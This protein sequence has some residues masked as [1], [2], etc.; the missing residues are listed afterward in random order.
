MQWRSGEFV[1]AYGVA[2]GATTGPMPKPW[3]T[4]EQQRG[5]IGW[6]ARIP[7]PVAGD[8]EPYLLAGRQ[9]QWDEAEGKREAYEKR[10]AEMRQERETAEAEAAAE[11][12]KAYQ[13]TEAKKAKDA[14]DLARGAYLAS[15]GTTEGWQRD[16]ERV[17]ADAAMER[18]EQHQRRGGSLISR[19]AML[20]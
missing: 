8:C 1:P 9:E 12:K 20:A 7:R 5:D 13:A 6:T 10:G 11:R 16:R 19:E 17:L 4:P 15:G 18:F 14:E 2:T 3:P